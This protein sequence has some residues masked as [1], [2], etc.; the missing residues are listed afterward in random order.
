M[1]SPTPSQVNHINTEWDSQHWV[2]NTF[3][4]CNLVFQVL[5]SFF[6]LINGIAKVPS[7]LILSSIVTLIVVVLA[8]SVS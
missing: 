5:P 3:V 4:A 6:I 7:W 1:P 8:Q 2:G